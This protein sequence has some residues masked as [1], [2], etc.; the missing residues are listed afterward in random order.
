MTNEW[1]TAIDYV[2]ERG[3]AVERARL[4]YLLHGESAPADVREQF[5]R[6]QRGD[7][8]W[9]PPWAAEYGSVDATCFQ[10][11]QADQLGLDRRSPLFID[12]V[13]FLA[14]RQ[15]ADGYW[16]EEADVADAAP[17]WAQPGET[18]A[19][20]YLTANCGFWTAVTGLV[21]TAARDAAA[22]LS[23]H[24]RA[25]GEL[26]SFLQTHWLAAALWQQRGL[27][28]EAS[29]TLGY[30]AQQAGELSAGNLAWMIVA[31]REG[32]VPAA[33]AAVAAALDRLPAL[34]DPAGH[35]PSDEGIENSVH[36]TIEALK[37]LQLG[38]RLA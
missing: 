14:E 4:R 18:A 22:Y 24:L 28:D 34:R 25:N 17:P 6:G 33:D 11:A 5:E 10:L 12:A 20:L 26:P 27:V 3:T 15:R 16:E 23:Y 35:W 37:A 30:L 2:Y 7:G 38:G 21:P 36:V 8:G 29:K 19:R 1:Q 32:G 31:L 13:R 9:S